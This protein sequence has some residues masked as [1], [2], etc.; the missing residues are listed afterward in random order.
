MLTV[1]LL[2]VVMPGL[3]WAG[4]PNRIGGVG[5]RAL[6][7]GGAYTAIADDVS[8]FYYNVAGI[9]Q[10]D[11]NL[12][13]LGSDFNFP[14]L[15]FKLPSD[16]GGYSEESANKVFAM[17]LTA[18]MFRLTDKL[19]LGGGVYTP[20]GLGVEYP[21]NQ[22]HG[23]LYRKSLLSLTNATLALSYEVSDTLSI[24]GGLDF[25]WSQFAYSA[26]FHQLGQ[27]VIDPLFLKN[28]GDGFGVG[29]R[30]GALWQPSDRF[31]CGVSYSAPMKVTLKGET[32]LSLFGLGLGRDN[33]KTHFTFPGRLGAGIAYKPSQRLLLAFDIGYF[34]YSG[35]DKMVF[36][37]GKLPTIPNNLGWRS[38]VSLNLGAEYQLNE[39]WFARGGVCWQGAP[40][41]DSTTN[42]AMPDAKGFAWT[43]GLGYK[44]GDWSVDVALVLA[45]AKREIEQKPGHLAPGEYG[46]TIPGISFATSYRF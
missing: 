41:P 17:P 26:P 6:G 22:H 15:S 33:F 27:L 1:M 10:V 37:F 12:I 19:V 39:N 28:A 11:N 25:G 20:Y 13:E 5:P 38:F 32:D 31:A 7:M 36:D 42:P 4:G 16:W 9:S 24:G 43:T 45:Q 2:L 8:A 40:F 29:W 3:A 34:D 30:I 44:K 21:K 23:M 18:G 46:A 35:A 14:K